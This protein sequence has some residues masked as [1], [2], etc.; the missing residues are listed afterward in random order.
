MATHLTVGKTGADYSTIAAAVAASQ[1]GTIDEWST[2]TVI[3]N[4]TYTETVLITPQYLKIIDTLGC[5]W[6]SN[7]WCVQI[8]DTNAPANV[9][10]E[11]VSTSERPQF[12]ASAQPNIHVACVNVANGEFSCDYWDFGATQSTYGRYL[13]ISSG[14]NTVTISHSTYLKNGSFAAYLFQ[15]QANSLNL[16]LDCCDFDAPTALIKNIKHLRIK[17]SKISVNNVLAAGAVDVENSIIKS[18]SSSVALVSTSTK[19]KI[20]NSVFVGDGANFLKSTA[21]ADDVF[22]QNCI[23]TGFNTVFDTQA[24][25][26]PQYSILWQNVTNYA[27]QATE[28]PGMIYASPDLDADF[29]PN[30]DSPAWGAGE[31]SGLTTDIIGNIRPYPGDNTESI[32]A[33]ERTWIPPP[34]P[35]PA[36]GESIKSAIA[37]KLKSGFAYTNEDSPPITIYPNIYKEK[38]VQGMKKPA[39]FIWVME[40]SQEENA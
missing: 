2:I 17:R 26:S 6:V 35:V 23:I 31:V 38:V 36:D 18:T 1:N 14:N 10:F 8:G 16:L 30:S 34:I 24:T 32:G 21:T 15:Q 29:R 7:T 39:F 12:L 28:G 40:V 5:K 37:L 25:F 33:Y 9:R 20:R 3:D 13:L 27:G 4:E 11:T 19:F 22:V